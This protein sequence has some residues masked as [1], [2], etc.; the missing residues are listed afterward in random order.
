[1][2]RCNEILIDWCPRAL[3]MGTNVVIILM[4]SLHCSFWLYSIFNDFLLLTPPHRVEGSSSTGNHQGTSH[5]EA[6]APELTPSS[7]TDI[8]SCSHEQHKDL[9]EKSFKVTQANIDQ[10]G[11]SDNKH[12]WRKHKSTLPTVRRGG[13]SILLWSCFAVRGAATLHRM[14]GI[15]KENN[16]RNLHLKSAA[17]Q[18]KTQL[19]LQDSDP[20]HTSKLDTDKAGVN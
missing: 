15:M 3:I 6:T 5:G 4:F 13:G 7:S 8:Y 10:F 17:R 18:L 14:V 19:F 9:P 2:M 12:V 16:L 20:K 1:M 11:H